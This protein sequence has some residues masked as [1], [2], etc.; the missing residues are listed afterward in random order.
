MKTVLR[1][2]NAVKNFSGFSVLAGINL[3]IMEGER[4]A[5][6]GPNGAGKSTFFNVIT[7]LYRLTSGRIFFLDKNITGWP[8]NKI[9][10]LGISRSFQI[11]NIFPKMTVFENV[12]N[13]IISKFRRSFSWVTLLN[14]DERIK[15][16]TDRII[17]LTALTDSRDILASELNYGAQRHLELALTLA[18]DPFLIMLD[19]PTA[20]L[21]VDETRKTVELIKQVTEGKTL[22]IVEHDMDVVFNLAD[23]VTV[24]NYGKILASGTLNEI[25]G[26]EEVKMAYLGRK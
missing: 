10:R 22:M 4:H 18:R 12:R 11:I 7:G 6:I 2:E 25:R 5:I 21:T 23:R 15:K 19:E 16:E 13:A 8:I 17:D 26:N 14:R 20:G 24:L 1:I 9:A 3:E